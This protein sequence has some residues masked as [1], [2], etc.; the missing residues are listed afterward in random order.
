V[1]L[2]VGLYLTWLAWQPIAWLASLVSLV[3]DEA[4]AATVT[5]FYR[6]E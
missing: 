3:R 2:I 6:E 4:H 5:E 1:I